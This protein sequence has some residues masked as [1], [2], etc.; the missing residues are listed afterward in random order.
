MIYASSGIFA[1]IA[2]AISIFITLPL[3]IEKFDKSITQL[4][5]IQ[6]KDKANPAKND[7][8]HKLNSFWLKTT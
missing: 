6:I 5:Q 2:N 8:Q 1:S 3:L 7:L 4:T